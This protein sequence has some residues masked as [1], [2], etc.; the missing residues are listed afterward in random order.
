M[1][2]PIA[3]LAWTLGLRGETPQ[4]RSAIATIALRGSAGGK[5]RVVESRSGQGAETV[6][7]NQRS[8]RILPVHTQLVHM[9]Q[10]RFDVVAERLRSHLGMPTVVC[11]IFVVV[12]R[13]LGEHDE[14][15]LQ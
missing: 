4:P 13:S 8:E 5:Y 14:S 9:R 6:G 10:V 15:A 12:R 2:K 1:V 11:V 3:R 7:V